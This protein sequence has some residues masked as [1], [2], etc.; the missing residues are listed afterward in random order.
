[1][2]LYS[3]IYCKWVTVS[4]LVQICQALTS[5]QDN[6]S[7]CKQISDKFLPLTLSTHLADPVRDLNSYLQNHPNGNLLA[8]Q[9]SWHLRQEGPDHQL[10]HYATAKCE[11]FSYVTNPV[12]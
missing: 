7:A 9:F 12:R 6:V 4:K 3:S 2:I 5:I 11:F 10:T 1:M 8:S